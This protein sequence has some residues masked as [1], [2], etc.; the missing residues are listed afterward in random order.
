[1]RTDGAAGA[2]PGRGEAAA[3]WLLVALPTLVLVGLVLV[4]A[5]S[6]VVETV[7]APGPDGGSG[8]TLSRYAD[9]FADGYSRANLSYTLVQTIAAT[10][11]ALAISLGLAIYLRFS[12]GPLARLVQALAM[13]PLFVPS[14]II[15]YALIRFLGPNGAFQTLLER[16]GITGYV[17]PYLT[18]VGPFI[19]FV[20]ES[21]SLPVLVISAGLTQVS[22]SAIEAARD[23]GAGRLRILW[24]ILLP[25]A[26]RSLTI[27]FAL[28]FLGTFGS[29][30]IP[31]MLGPA[32][33]EMMGVFMQRTYG[34]L[35]E[36][37]AARVQATIS[38]L[39]CSVIGLLYVRLLSE[40]RA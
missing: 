31:Y 20:W 40:K 14:I 39:I 8:L 7:I 33:P 3:G 17:S 27:A 10:L 22:D 19:G 32:A 5:G 4:P 29:Y 2:R 15:S 28:T 34:Q 23:L 26:R 13:F 6:A 30:T 25:Q 38:F 9:F 35:M 36:F 1:M 18:P 16:L 24:E 11:A 37:D 21:I 12:S